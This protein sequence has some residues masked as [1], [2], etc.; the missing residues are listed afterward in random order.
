MVLVF[1]NPTQPI[2]RVGQPGGLTRPTQPDRILNPAYNP[3]TQPDRFF[4]PEF[5][6]AFFI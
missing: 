3:K 4:N 5:F 1:I 6:T 2:T